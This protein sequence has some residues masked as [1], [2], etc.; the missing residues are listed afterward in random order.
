MR[1][2]LRK[3]D[4][5]TEEKLLNSLQLIKPLKYNTFFGLSS[6]DNSSCDKIGLPSVLKM[7]ACCSC[8]VPATKCCFI[9]AKAAKYFRYC[10]SGLSKILLDHMSGLFSQ[11][12]AIFLRFLAQRL[13]TALLDLPLGPSVVATQ[14]ESLIV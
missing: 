6:S 2:F 13:E 7:A 11:E 9:K 1:T 3:F 8:F 12:L 5:K 10:Y 4:R 14:L